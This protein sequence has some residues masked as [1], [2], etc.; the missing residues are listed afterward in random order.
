MCKNLLPYDELISHVAIGG[1][2]RGLLAMA[3]TY[4]LLQVYDLVNSFD[5]IDYKNKFKDLEYAVQFA[6]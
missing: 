5:R 3:R 6:F 2:A 1:I 4:G